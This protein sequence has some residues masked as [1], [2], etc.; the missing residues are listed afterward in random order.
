MAKFKSYLSNKIPYH[1]CFKKSTFD[2]YVDR[3][4]PGP[5]TDYQ[6]SKAFFFCLYN[7]IN[8]YERW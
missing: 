6:Y 7:A 1:S 2:N 4:R 5:D 8:C 3:F